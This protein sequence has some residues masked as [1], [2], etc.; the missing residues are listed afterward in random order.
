MFWYPI[1][2]LVY[3]HINFN[4]SIICCLFLE[5]NIFPF[6]I[7][8][9]LLSVSEAFCGD[10]IV[11]LLEILLP[12][13]S[14]IV[15][16]VFWIALFVEVLGAYVADGLAL[17]KRFLGIFPA[18]VFTYIFTKVFAHTFS[19]RQKSVNFYNYSIFWLNLNSESFLYF[20][21]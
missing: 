15:S 17:I 16:A 8:V 2:L 3:C 7:S 9:S 6:G 4:W 21:F 12:I 20:T 13:K 19:K 10:F 18:Y 11:I 5:M 14:P 1:I